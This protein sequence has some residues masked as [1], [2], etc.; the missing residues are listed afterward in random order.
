[1]PAYSIMRVE[2][3]GRGAVYGLQIEAN[4]KEEDHEK[5]EFERSDIDW[6]KT[7]ENIFL[8][9]TEQ[10]NREITKQVKEAGAKERK[11]SVVLLD[12]LYTASPEWF[13]THSKEEW[14]NYFQD[15]LTF[16]RDYYGEHVIN[17]V[18][19]L[20]EATPHMQVASIPLTDDGRLSAKEIMGNRRDYRSRQNI[21]Y[22]E[23]GK[24]YGLERGEIHDQPRKH[25]L[26][27]K[28]RIARNEEQI[29]ASE[30]KLTQA[31]QQM[32][33][34]E[35]VISGQQEQILNSDNSI[36]EIKKTLQEQEA[37]RQRNEDYIQKQ[38][39]QIRKNQRNIDQQ[40][41][42]IRENRNLLDVQQKSLTELDNEKLPFYLSQNK[43]IKEMGGMR[44]GKYLI[45]K[46]KL[47]QL[48]AK[49][50]KGEK[51]AERERQVNAQY[52]E[53]SQ[54]KKESIRR[55]HDAE[56]KERNAESRLGLAREIEEGQAYRNNVEKANEAILQ[57][58]EAQKKAQAMEDSYIRMSELLQQMQ[59]GLRHA[60]LTRQ[61]R[62]FLQ[63]HEKEFQEFQRDEK[64]REHRGYSR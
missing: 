1:M 56:E 37:A 59:S 36:H 3:R 50:K 7:D 44:G 19:H 34:N 54:M 25:E 27:Q 21:F 32:E 31:Q 39:E 20:D 48:Y 30:Q 28:G 15:C 22:D 61:E 40:C 6:S 58:E 43:D 53:I 49:A 47:E 13:E 12:G 4:R 24:K 41:E 64:M 33:R 62:R 9:H 42:K 38:S 18:I 35:N 51:L 5:R 23:V 52:Q 26:S 17:A 14:I 63:K 46:D 29:A 57:A 45:K 16:H 10:W 11:D 60:E 55:F 8:I 2:K